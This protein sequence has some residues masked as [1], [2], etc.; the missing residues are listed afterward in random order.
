MRKLNQGGNAGGL[1]E[2][3]VRSAGTRKTGDATTKSRKSRHEEDFENMEVE[4]VEILIET[5]EREMKMA[6]DA[7]RKI[8]RIKN[9]T[10]KAKDAKLAPIEN[11]IA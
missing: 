7:K 11:A 3:S 9:Q 5:A 1:T 10:G 4:E 2:K 6:N 8:G